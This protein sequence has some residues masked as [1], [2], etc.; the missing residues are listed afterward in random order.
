MRTIKPGKYEEAIEFIKRNKGP[1]V[2]SK[3]GDDIIFGFELGDN[4]KIIFIA[5]FKN[6]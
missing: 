4:I 6:E 5:T 1:Y 2:R 3:V